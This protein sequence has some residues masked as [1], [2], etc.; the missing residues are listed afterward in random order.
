MEEGDV[1]VTCFTL[2]HS[3]DLMLQT[4]NL[5]RGHFHTDISSKLISYSQAKSN[6]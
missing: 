5:Q 3:K 2:A 4:A 6:T 1:I